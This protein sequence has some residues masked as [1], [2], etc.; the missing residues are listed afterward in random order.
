[1]GTAT[2]K[3]K[4]KRD[5][6]EKQDQSGSYYSLSVNKHNGYVELTLADCHR[7]ITWAF[8]RPNSKRAIAK[9]KKIKKLIDAM[10]DHLV[11]P[12]QPKQPDTEW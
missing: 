11:V 8:G 4:S 7:N 3:L 12:G 1:M 5:W 10:H 9:I 6:L 2:T